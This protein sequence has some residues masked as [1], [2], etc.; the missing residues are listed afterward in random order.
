MSITEDVGAN[1]VETDTEF[2]FIAE[3]TLTIFSLTIVG[4]PIDLVQFEM[5]EIDPTSGVGEIILLSLTEH[6]FRIVCS[7]RNSMELRVF[8]CPRVSLK[9]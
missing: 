2:F 8:V 3:V 1:V 7:C 4:D 5:F 6:S 9:I